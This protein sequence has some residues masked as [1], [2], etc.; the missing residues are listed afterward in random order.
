MRL[1]SLRILPFSDFDCP[2][3]YLQVGTLTQ[4][5]DVAGRGLGQVRMAKIEDCKAKCDSD[6][7]CKSFG[8]GHHNS[9]TFTECEI[10]IVDFPNNNWSKNGPLR[11]CKKSKHTVEIPNFYFRIFG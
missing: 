7:R 10:D 1:C 4:K 11:M 8:F 5:N 6:S 9:K 3:G 2:T